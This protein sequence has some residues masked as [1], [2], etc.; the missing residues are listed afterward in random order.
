MWVDSGEMDN[1]SA[2]VVVSATAPGSAGS[3]LSSSASVIP[4]HVVGWG[5][6]RL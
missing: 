6:L 2:P 1:S 5:S 4:F 3:V